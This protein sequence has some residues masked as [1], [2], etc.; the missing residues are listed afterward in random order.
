MLR[1]RPAGPLTLSTQ[2][3]LDLVQ[4]WVAQARGDRQHQR[5]L[6][7]RALRVAEREQ[8]RAPIAWAS[9]WLH[10]VIASDPALLRLHGSF[11]ASVGGTMLDDPS[12][13]RTTRLPVLTAPVS[14]LTERELE[15]L[16]RLG[17]LST[18][19]EI[20]ADLFLSPNTVKTHLKSL[21][22]KLEVTRRSDAFRRGRSLGLC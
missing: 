18:N 19:I 6:V 8:L 3:G 12:P 4:A 2:V 21:Y 1:I 14:P 16:Q 13:E 15:V 5:A 7:D 22:R 20:A 9:S 10:E 11:L 17:T